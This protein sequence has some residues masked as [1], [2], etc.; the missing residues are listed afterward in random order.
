MSIPAAV[1][2][3][4][5]DFCV[6][7]F[8]GVCC[9]V[10]VHRD[11]HSAGQMGAFFVK[12][13]ACFRCF[14]DDQRSDDIVEFVFLEMNRPVVFPGSSR[15][16]PASFCS[17]RQLPVAE[18]SLFFSGKRQSSAE[19]MQ[20]DSLRI[21]GKTLRPPADCCHLF[22]DQHNQPAAHWMQPTCR[23]LPSIAGNMAGVLRMCH[24]TASAC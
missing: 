18:R 19:R 8:G 3:H 13:K 10:F 22:A 9:S 12:H 5:F 15:Q 4:P 20:A 11:L 6:D 1:S 23:T 7:L 24:D 16:K 14:L 17:Y 21:T 2:E